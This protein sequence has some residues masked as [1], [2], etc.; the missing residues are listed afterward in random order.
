M[1]IIAMYAD[2]G[3]ISVNPS[4]I[5]GTWAF[6]FVDQHG[7]RVRT[8]AGVVTPSSIDLDTVTNNVTELL[9]LIYGIEQLPDRWSGTVYSDSAVSLQRV[10]H[11]GALNN[12]PWWLVERMQRLR[13]SGRLARMTGVLLDGHPTRA[14][15]A[16]GVG[17]RGNPVSEHNVWCDTACTAAAA[18]HRK[19][20]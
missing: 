3:V 2:G 6:C 20:A 7:Q 10:F 12:V 18:R 17:K 11:C 19:G 1:T 8:A 14:Q 5:G 15:L 9:A 13:A 16:A 4:P